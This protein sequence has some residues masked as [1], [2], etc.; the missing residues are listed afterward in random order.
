MTLQLRFTFPVLTLENNLSSS[1]LFEI[2]LHPSV[3]DSNIFFTLNGRETVYFAPRRVVWHTAEKQFGCLLS[4]L[5]RCIWNDLLTKVTSFSTA[6][7]T[8]HLHNDQR[9]RNKQKRGCCVEVW[10]GPW[11]VIIVLLPSRLSSIAAP[12]E[13]WSGINKGA[14]L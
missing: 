12:S 1:S 13:N 14:L 5:K 9:H 3:P 8:L 11:D 2:F 7:T 10:S 4:W 6:T